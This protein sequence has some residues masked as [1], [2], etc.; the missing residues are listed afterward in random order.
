MTDAKR[1][2]RYRAT[3][4]DAARWIVGSAVEFEG[5]RT[6][7]Y[8]RGDPTAL[9]PGLYSGDGGVALFLA[10]VVDATDEPQ[11]RAALEDACRNLI[12]HQDYGWFGLYSGVAGMAWA[13]RRGAE[14]L[15]SAELRAGVEQLL[16]SIEGNAVRIGD[17]VEWPITPIG[18]GPWRE[19]YHGIAGTAL[20][21]L[22]L[23][24][25][26]TAVAAGR[27]LLDLAIPAPTGNWWQSRPDDA[28]PAPNIAH[29][30]TGIA[31]FLATLAMAT[32]EQSFADAALDGAAYL[33]SIARKDD[34][35]CAVHHHEVDG[36]DLYTLGWC[37]GPPGLACLF[38]RLGELTGSHEWLDWATAAARTVTTSGVPARLYPGFW[39]N[40]AQC[41]GSSGVAD[42]FLG[43][44][45]L[46]GGDSYRDFA[47][48]VLDDII[49]RATV[50]EDGT[51]W[52]NIEFRNDPPELPAETGYMQGAAGIGSTLLRGYRFLAR[53]DL[54][55]WLPSWPFV[56]TNSTAE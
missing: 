39:D 32:G 30:T 11:M 28:K 54:G 55:P 24:R 20:V 56:K 26:D 48:V 43:L 38:L 49:E 40:V 12:R 2:D 14:A 5:R 34:G 13:V 27:R 44:H 3:A 41:C 46:T 50:D 4:E 45:A 51:R 8:R 37:S 23:G 15:E 35:T 29:G 25:K 16:D 1:A 10:D 33:L 52:H 53:T 21:L 7:P 31:Y 17:T 19:L 18:R 47:L 9:D 6:W 42:F 22:E 36:T